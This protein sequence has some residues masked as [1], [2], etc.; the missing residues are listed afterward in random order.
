MHH[1]DPRRV[2]AK[3]FVGVS[4]FCV[5]LCQNR[6]ASKQRLL[7]QVLDAAG[8]PASAKMGLR[9]RRARS[10]LCGGSSETSARSLLLSVH[11]AQEGFDDWGL[12]LFQL[13]EA[14]LLDST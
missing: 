12:D 1:D 13:E 11:L 9:A 6:A 8:E 5:T 7:V 3:K 4:P 2:L 10:G 14:T